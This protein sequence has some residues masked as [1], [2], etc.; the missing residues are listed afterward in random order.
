MVFALLTALLA[1]V[2]SGLAGL[3][4]GEAVAKRSSKLNGWYFLMPFLV[5]AGL[6]LI[7][8]EALRILLW[9]IGFDERPSWQW[10]SSS[11]LLL[12]L[13]ASIVVSMPFLVGSIIG[14]HQFES[15]KDR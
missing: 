4:A 2:L 1:I 7:G 13:I 6:I 11:F 10:L 9:A 12:N 15:E 14:F 5:S 8:F 3:C